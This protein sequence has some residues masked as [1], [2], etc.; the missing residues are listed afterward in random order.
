MAKYIYIYFFKLRNIQIV[1]NVRVQR[2]RAKVKCKRWEGGQRLE[3]R[4]QNSKVK[5]H[6]PE[7]SQG[8]RGQWKRSKVSRLG[9]EIKVLNSKFES[10]RRF[11]QLKV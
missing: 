3:A 6:K 9:K 7:G 2:L 1:K 8:A 4:C 11:T 5:C 10:F